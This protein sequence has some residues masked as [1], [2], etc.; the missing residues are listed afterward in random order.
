MDG[1]FGHCEMYKVVT[2]SENNEILNS[3]TVASPKGCGCKSD[4]AQTL[5]EKGVTIMLVGGI[6]TGA[7]NKLSSAGIN[8]V[9]GCSGDVEE[10]SLK[11]A[12]GEIADTGSNCE[13]H[14]HHHDHNHK[15]HHQGS[16]SHN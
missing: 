8:V 6:G 12:K 15:G 13:E 4:I 2:L 11:F 5:A 10:L 1:H 14:D 9:R 3:E 7:V 16:C